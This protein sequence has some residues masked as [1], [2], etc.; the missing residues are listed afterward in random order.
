[1]L[2][3]TSSCELRGLMQ[4]GPA[5]EEGGALAAPAAPP[6]VLRSSESQG[7][8]FSTD[9]EQEDDGV[10]DGVTATRKRLVHRRGVR[11]FVD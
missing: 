11:A 8:S 2:P 5:T 9:E 4:E 3:G 10:G 7:S 1:M 6:E